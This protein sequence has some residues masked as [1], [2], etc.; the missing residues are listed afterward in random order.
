MYDAKSIK[1]K[2]ATHGHLPRRFLIVCMRYAIRGVILHI[3]VA[4]ALMKKGLR[5]SLRLCGCA[6]REFRNDCRV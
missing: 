4:D 1:L 5:A 3:N 2:L 6:A